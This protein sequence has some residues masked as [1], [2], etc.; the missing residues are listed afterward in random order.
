MWPN[1]QFIEL[2]RRCHT[3]GD[4]YIAV[5]LAEHEASLRTSSARILFVCLSY[6]RITKLI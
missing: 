6:E 4:N 2:V 3:E 1:L 5:K